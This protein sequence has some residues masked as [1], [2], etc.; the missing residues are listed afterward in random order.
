M[1]ETRWSPCCSGAGKG[2]EVGAPGVAGRQSPRSQPTRE[3]WVPKKG[4]RQVPEYVRGVCTQLKTQLE[5]TEALLEDEQT[6]RQKLT[7]EFEEVRAGQG[8][9]RSRWPPGASAGW[10]KPHP[11]G[12]GITVP[13]PRP[14]CVGLA[15]SPGPH[16]VVPHARRPPSL[17]GPVR[18]MRHL[19]LNCRAPSPAPRLRTRPV[20]CRGS[21][22][23][24]VAPVPLG[25][26][27]RRPCS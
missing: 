12:V 8:A 25:Q 3:P 16:R 22:R 7:A 13:R 24:F 1:E 23:S 15:Y 26:K 19:T 4:Q 20:G 27:Q 5:R 10:A 2:S 17:S 11:S 14:V 9:E 18:L 6:R 21:W